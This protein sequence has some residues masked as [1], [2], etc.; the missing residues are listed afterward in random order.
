MQQLILDKCSINIRYYDLL[1]AAGDQT[2][3]LDQK[4]CCVIF[5]QLFFLSRLQFPQL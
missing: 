1:S 4:T 5:S 2:W 3:N